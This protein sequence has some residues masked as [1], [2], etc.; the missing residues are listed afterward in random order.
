[1]D[2]LTVE[3]KLQVGAHREH[4]PFHLEVI[5]CITDDLSQQIALGI[6]LMTAIQRTRPMH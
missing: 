1:M 2:I 3:D 6:G 4:R 5:I